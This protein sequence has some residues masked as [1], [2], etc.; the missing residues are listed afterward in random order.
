MKL[1]ALAAIWLFAQV[2]VAS[3]QM[4]SDG[5]MVNGTGEVKIKPNYVEIDLRVSGKAEIADDA[6]VKYNQALK[7][8]LEAFKALKLANLKVIERGM[9]LS[10]GDSAA[11]MQAMMRGQPAPMEKMQIEVMAPLRLQLSGVDKLPAVEVFR[12]VGKLLDVA[13]DSG[14]VLGPTSAETYRMRYYG[15][16]SNQQTQTMVRFVVKDLDRVREEAY[17]KAIADARKRAERLAKLTG[18]KLGTATWVQETGVSGDE[19][20]TY[21]GPQYANQPAPSSDEPQLA[22]ESLSET[23]FRVRLSVR[24]S[25]QSENLKTA[26]R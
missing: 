2:H 9:T 14:A 12:T 1:T 11:A 19:M 18:V 4:G 8:S 10:P 20:S 21:S 25:I 17:G 24:Y 22:S 6:M 16:N 26:D 3:A 15:Y 23:S 7:N 5:V 13:R